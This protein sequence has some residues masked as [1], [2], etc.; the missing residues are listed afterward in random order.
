M[1]RMAR[2]RP[3]ARMRGLAVVVGEAQQGVAPLGG[4]IGAPLDDVGAVVAVLGD[5]GVSCAQGGAVAG[6]QAGGVA[7][8]LA[9]GVVVV[10]LALDGMADVVEHPGDDIADHATPGVA[11]VERPVGIG[12]DELHLD[13]LPGAVVDP[14]VVRAAGGGGAE[15]LQVPVVAPG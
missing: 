4:Q 6:L 15:H 11:D 5:D 9:A 8:H 10:V 1:S 7:G 14:G 2:A 12:R 13:P 3:Q